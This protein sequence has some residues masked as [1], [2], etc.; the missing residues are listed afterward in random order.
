MNIDKQMTTKQSII[1]VIVIT[2]AVIIFQQVVYGQEQIN[3]STVGKSMV[4]KLI[5]DTQR[6][7][8]IGQSYRAELINRIENSTYLTF[9]RINYNP[10]GVNENEKIYDGKTP[11]ELQE[12]IEET[13]REYDK[14][15][16][17]E[18]DMTV[19]NI[20]ISQIEQ[21]F[22]SCVAEGKIK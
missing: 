22:K 4:D 3:N 10:T 19:D 2:I 11:K 13:N 6:G 1:F 9:P 5:E 20:E 14:K 21:V 16:K 8:Q 12:E 7:Q 17:Q 18:W 15:L